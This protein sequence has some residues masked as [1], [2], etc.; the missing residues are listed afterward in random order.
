MQLSGAAA[1][2]IVHSEPA[3]LGALI[4]D[5]EDVNE[6]VIAEVKTI[7]I[8]G[9]GAADDLSMDG[10][11]PP[12]PA[13]FGAT[14]Q[15]LIGDRNGDLADSFDVT[16]CSPSWVAQALASTDWS[17]FPRQRSLPQTVLPG[18]AIWFM[19][20]W[21]AAAFRTAVEAVCAD[22]SPGPDWGTVA[23]RIGR[24]IPWEFDY[25][26]DAHVNGHFGER[27]PPYQ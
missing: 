24:S 20:S 2:Q 13:H 17:R 16:I 14:A 10:F 18:A 7:L 25:K 22:A 1:S 4:R 27:F 21:N 19:P 3:L 12:D 26:Y 11:A 5:D 23:S 15:I 9:D 8:G 6:P